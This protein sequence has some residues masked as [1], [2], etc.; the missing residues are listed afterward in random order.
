MHAIGVSESPR[1][2]LDTMR[3]V[4]NWLRGKSV[5][6]ANESPLKIIPSAVNAL[7]REKQVDDS[8]IPH[9]L[10]VPKGY[11]GLPLS[12]FLASQFDMPRSFLQQ[13]VQRHGVHVERMDPTKKIPMEVRYNQG[14]TV[15]TG[16]LVQVTDVRLPVKQREDQVIN[17]RGQDA[18]PAD[19]LAEALKRRVVYEDDRILVINKP[20]GLAVQSGHD[21]KHNLDQLLH[22]LGSDLKLVHRLDRDASGLLI[23]AK[24]A[25]S[26]RSLRESLDE[27]R[28]DPKIEKIYQVMVMGTPKAAFGEVVSQVYLS[29]TYPR[30]R[31][32]SKPALRKSLLDPGKP[33]ITQWR[34]M[35]TYIRKLETGRRIKLS[36]LEMRPITGRKHQLRVHCSEQLQ[37]PIVGDCK[38]GFY[39]MDAWRISPRPLHL[40]CHTLRLKRWGRDQQDV[41]ITAP[42]PGHFVRTMDQY[43]L[44]LPKRPKLKKPAIRSNVRPV[45]Q[46]FAN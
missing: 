33:A 20:T 34:H 7:F 44:F 24:G 31:V 42:L 8:W 27:S 39:R 4:L 6:T 1:S 26:A 28:I 18:I 35:G 38:Y 14:V 3:S 25:E 19:L 13:L 21:I 12:H 11:D 5:P 15:R 23:L 36:M 16:D 37:L 32:T 45:Y 46:R 43:R 22:V 9:R 2:I 10:T 30:E 40:H 41:E 17:W 29:G